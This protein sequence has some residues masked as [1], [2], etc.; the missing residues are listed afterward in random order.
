MITHAGSGHLSSCLSAA[1][2]ISA[3]FFKILNSKNRDQFILSKGHAAP[4]LYVAYAELKLLTQKELL[5]FRTFNSPLEGHP[6]PQ[7]FGVDSATGSL[8]QGLSIAIGKALAAQMHKSPAR[9]Y[10]LLGDSECSEGQVW[11]AIEL[12]PYYKLKNIV[13]IIDANGF[14]QANSSLIDA[15]EK[16]YQKIFTAHGWFT[17]IV[18]GHNIAHIMRAFERAHISKAPAM[19]IARTHKG[20]GIPSI[21]DRV[22]WH[23]KA[24]SHNQ[25]EQFQRELAQTHKKYI[26]HKVTELTPA[27]TPIR[28]KKNLKKRTLILPAPPHIYTQKK[29]YSVRKSCGEALATAGKSLKNLI[30]LDADVKNSTYTDIFEKKYPK[31]FIECFIAEQ[32]M[33]SI[34]MGISTMGYTPVCATFAAFLTRAY[35]QLRMAGISKAAFGIIGTHV[36]VSVGQDGPSQMGLEDIAL[37]RTIPNSTILY[38]CDS[39]STWKITELLLNNTTGICYLRAT[40]EE[41]KTIYTPNTPFKIGGSHVLTQ[42]PNDIACIIA[43]GITVHEALAAYTLLARQNIFV[44]IID[45]YSIKPLDI[46]TIKK[47]A[48]RCKNRVLVVEDHYAAGGIAEAVRAAAPELVITSLAIQKLPHSGSP[49]ELRAY[50]KI[51][52]QSIVATVN[53]LLKVSHG[54][55]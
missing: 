53:N 16:R 50:M 34:A 24:P 31:Q 22:E 49:Q 20:F 36:G 35:D 3:L 2:I 27:Y 8:G 28:Q 47:Q 45:L 6:T 42:S 38:P 39:I 11:E 1:D 7:F 40:R 46:E 29:L 19:I 5:N 30:I 25:L 54:L 44:A 4:L 43:A 51:D 55:D 33:I 48:K 21:Q 41:T 37:F 12:A 13:G 15:Q 14:G 18:D 9:F 26:S 32:N 52:A 17:Q 23:G 10:V